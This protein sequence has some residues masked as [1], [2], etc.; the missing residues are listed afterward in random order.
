METLSQLHPPQPRIFAWSL[1]THSSL[2][3]IYEWLWTLLAVLL[4]CCKYCHDLGWV[5][6][7]L[8]SPR[9]LVRWPPHL[10]W[11]IH[12]HSTV[13]QP[14]TP[15]GLPWPFHHS[16]LFHLWDNTLVISHCNHPSLQE[17][18]FPLLSL[19]MPLKIPLLK[20]HYNVKSTISQKLLCV[21]LP[22]ESTRLFCWK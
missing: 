10:W 7:P 8:R 14:P 21:L 15:S 11:Y 17:V 2:P 3:F 9:P 16:R 5:R 1:P 19:P 18:S 22:S 12:L 13:L 6:G 20:T 4:L